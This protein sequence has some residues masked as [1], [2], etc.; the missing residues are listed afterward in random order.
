ME[1][2]DVDN[3]SDK[4]RKLR[5]IINLREEENSLLDQS[6]VTENTI[7]N[8]LRILDVLLNDQRVLAIGDSDLTALSIAIFGKPKE[9]VVTD[10]DKRLTDL[11]FEANMEYDLPV[12][13]VYHDMRIKIIEIL[14]NQFSLIIMEPPRSRAGITVFLSRGIQCIQSGYEANV[15]ITVPNSGEIREFFDEFCNI[16]NITIIE[17][18]EK[19][20]QYL[21]SNET[22]DFLRLEFPKDKDPPIK[23]HWIEPFFAYEENTII[24]EY[25]CMCHEIIPVGI[26]QQF[27][28]IDELRAQGHSCGHKH[29]FAFHSKV[30]LL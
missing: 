3:F 1:T 18:H 19:I 24:K 12:R 26:D 27:E 9:V 2:L 23:S 8:R 14:L 15:F 6:Y 4:I 17:K 7:I 13:F 29:V 10:I 5:A 20:T 25:R 16:H 22:G 21:N 11:L 28:T 30:K